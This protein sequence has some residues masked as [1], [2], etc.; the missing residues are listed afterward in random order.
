MLLCG[1]ES[2]VRPTNNPHWRWDGSQASYCLIQWKH[3]L[4]VAETVKYEIVGGVTSDNK[5][6]LGDTLLHSTKFILLSTACKSIQ[7]L[8]QSLHRPLLDRFNAAPIAVSGQLFLDLIGAPI[9]GWKTDSFVSGNTR[10]LGPPAGVPAPKG[11]LLLRPETDWHPKCWPGVEDLIIV[12][13]E[14]I[15]EGQLREILSDNP[16]LTH[17]CRLIEMTDTSL[18]LFP[19]DPKLPIPATLTADVESATL[20][21][22]SLAGGLLPGNS[23]VFIP[24]RVS[25]LPAFEVPLEDPQFFTLAREYFV[26]GRFDEVRV[27]LREDAILKFCRHPKSEFLFLGMSCRYCEERPTFHAQFDQLAGQLAARGRHLPMPYRPASSPVPLWLLAELL[28]PPN[29]QTLSLCLLSPLDRD[30]LFKSPAP[31]TLH[32]ASELLPFLS[33]TDNWMAFTLLALREYLKTNEV[34]PLNQRRADLEALLASV[35][36]LMNSDD[37]FPFLATFK[38][39]NLSSTPSK[40][41]LVQV[42]GWPTKLEKTLDNLSKAIRAENTKFALREKLLPVGRQTIPGFQLRFDPSPAFLHLRVRRPWFAVYFNSILSSSLACDCGQCPGSA[43][44]RIQEGLRQFDSQ[45]VSRFTELT[46]D[47]RAKV[48]DGRISWDWK[49]RRAVGEHEFFS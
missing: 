33:A 4:P 46:L 15:R 10:Q 34:V 5:L 35:T 40:Q 17:A 44:K 28:E 36:P 23:L 25:E 13:R 14:P 2:I 8:L 41:D 45:L 19:L 43:E 22:V 38:S 9:D 11:V 47:L 12:A 26:A 3:E 24:T 32:N 27:Q 37:S 7:A 21:P 1:D 49:H 16:T 48:D 42:F 31:V 29:L 39:C 30:R 6:F 20:S 18:D